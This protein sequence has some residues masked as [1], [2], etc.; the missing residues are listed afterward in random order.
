MKTKRLLFFIVIVLSATAASGPAWGAQMVTDDVRS[1]AKQAVEQE[2]ALKTVAAPNT[3][4][5]LYFANRTG[6]PDLDPLQKGLTVMLITDLSKVKNLTVVERVRLQAL[7]EEMKLGVSGLVTESTAP[8]VG[9]LLGAHWLVGGNLLG[10]RPSPL[11]IKS[12][13]LDVPTT[14]LAGQACVEGG[15]EELLRMEKD[16]VLEVVKF[17]KIVPTTQEEIELKKPITTSVKA[18]LDFSKCIDLG[19]R[20]DYQGACN[21]CQSALKAD[22]NFDL[23]R[24]AMNESCGQVSTGRVNKSTDLLRSLRD[25]TSLTNQQT[26]HESDRRLVTPETAGKR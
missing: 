20:K 23:A 21:S 26:P 7:V 19:D 15:L 13:V 17:L 3:V 8:R 16:L 1:W 18:L 4:A 9:N 24:D 5:V 2:K 10:G 14:Q 12:N 22:P 11:Q 25:D 6:E